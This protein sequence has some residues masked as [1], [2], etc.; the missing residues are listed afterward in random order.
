MLGLR[1]QPCFEQPIFLTPESLMQQ[2][3]ALAELMNFATIS[4]RRRGRIN[5]NDYT[6]H[7]IDRGTHQ[8]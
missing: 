6:D 4:Q 3:P 5:S 7:P 1:V 8:G 2:R